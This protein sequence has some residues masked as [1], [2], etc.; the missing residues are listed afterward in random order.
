MTLV[1]SYFVY[2]FSALALLLAVSL[3]YWSPRSHRHHSKIMS[4]AHLEAGAGPN[5]LTVYPEWMLFGDSI[6]QQ[7]FAAGGL[8]QHMSEVYQRRA[9]IINRGYGGYN[10]EW[11]LR[12]L[13]Y[14]RICTISVCL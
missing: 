7:S 9:D 14:V 1:L 5:V 8:G 2:C 6:T 3:T 4:N 11:A 10:T 12:I 13:P